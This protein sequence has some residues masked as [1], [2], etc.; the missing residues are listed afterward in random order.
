MA[1]DYSTM[2]TQIKTRYIDSTTPGFPKLNNKFGSLGKLLKALLVTGGTKV[3]VTSLIAD[4]STNIATITLPSN[5]GLI[6]NTVITLEGSTDVSLNNMYR[7]LNYDANTITIKLNSMPT[8]TDVTSVTVS[9]AALGYTIAYDDFANSGVICF[10]NKS[11]KSP[12]ILKIIDIVPPNGYLP[13]WSKYARVVAGQ[14]I[15]NQGNFV[16]NVKTPLHLTIPNIEVSGNGVSGAGGVHGFLKWDYVLS[17]TT[18]DDQTEVA[19]DF[20]TYP[21]NWRIIGDDNT[22]YLFIQAMGNGWSKYNICSFGN[23]NTNNVA[24]TTNLLVTGSDRAFA[25]NITSN[26]K[27]GVAWRVGFS[28]TGDTVGNYLFTTSTGINFNNLFFTLF[29]L[30]HT[31]DG[32]YCYWPSRGGININAATG[33][34]LTSPMHI[35]DSMNEFRGT[36]RGIKYLYGTGPLPDGLI[37]EKGNSLILNTKMFNWDSTQDE[38]IP[39]LFNL[40]DWEAV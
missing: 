26:G 7:V 35:K 40:K 4:N 6:T 34:L 38:A 23:Y 16:N 15:D 3:S 27:S 8:S 1:T 19:T 10:K 22:F 21:T 28:K 39:Y 25:A 2:N 29:G 17:R 24:E 5:H 30:F 14:N 31:I 32:D 9:V 33:Q 37:L 18:G 36:L 12:A 13:T 20:G 11:V